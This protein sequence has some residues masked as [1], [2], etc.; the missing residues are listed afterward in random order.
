MARVALAVALIAVASIAGA[1]D[2]ALGALVDPVFVEANL[3]GRRL[4]IIDAR[5]AREFIEAHI[6]GAQSL[7]PESLRSSNHGVPGEVYP[8]EVLAVVV[9]RLGLGAGSATIVYGGGG[10]AD[11]TLVATALTAAGLLRVAVLDGGFARWKAEGRPLAAD[12][13]RIEPS[14][15]RLTPQPS[16]FIGYDEVRKAVDERSALL[17]DVR[18]TEAYEKGH[19]PGAV[20]R[21]WGLDFVPS[22]QP[23][24]GTFLPTA[25][26][27]AQYRALGATGNKP[28]I[29]YCNSGHTAS[30]AFY[31]LRFRL[32]LPG[33]RLY[34]GSMLEW[35]AI[36]DAPI[37]RTAPAVPPAELERAR[38]AAKALTGDLAARLMQEL[39]AGGPAGAVSVCAEVA[40]E[41][42]RSHSTA[43]LT[44]RRVSSRAR[45]PLDRP[46]A[47]EAERL[48]RFEAAVAGGVRPEE[49]SEVVEQDGVRVLR[50]MRPIM[51]GT[52]CLSCHGDP[53]AFDPAVKA[54]LAE[55]YPNDA[56][57][58]YR[59]GDLRGAVSV[60]VAIPRAP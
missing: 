39:Q 26:V 35:T 52:L 44:V 31:T 17:L 43:G 3:D 4:A 6:P 27:A 25:A 10:D 24:A 46:D 34:D 58:G 59:E 11:A 18:S 9:S 32:G 48:A 15:P 29:V 28:I 57:T 51:A 7:P 50:L 49:L 53:A 47:F 54:V 1:Q 20:S 23:L 12:R 19:I 55:R 41:L 8:P 33:V 37:E 42:A 14:S 36:P 21:P 30:V 16:L 56:A 60:T 13:P 2:A 45:N 22:G 40:P 5:P 38:A